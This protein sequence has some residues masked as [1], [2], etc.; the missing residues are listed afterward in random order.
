MR[1]GLI[2]SIQKQVEIDEP[3]EA[4]R[5]QRC[6]Q[7]SSDWDVIVRRADMIVD[8]MTEDQL[9]LGLQRLAPEEPNAKG[10]G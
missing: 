1:E 10:N 4:R 2:H 8:T 5:Q 9:L 6:P 3:E 7:T